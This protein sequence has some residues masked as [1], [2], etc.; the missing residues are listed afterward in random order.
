MCRLLLGSFV[1]QTIKHTLFSY[2]AFSH[3]ALVYIHN[4]MHFTNKT[5]K[6]LTFHAAFNLLKSIFCL[7]N[8]HH[9]Q[10]CVPNYRFACTNVVNRSGSRNLI[11]RRE[12]SKT[13]SFQ[14]GGSSTQ[15]PLLH[16]FFQRRKKKL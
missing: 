7:S 13:C 3:E 10:T 12:A 8:I 4:Q 6:A 11:F 15:K 9:T 5:N 16:I 2:P 1:K 14:H